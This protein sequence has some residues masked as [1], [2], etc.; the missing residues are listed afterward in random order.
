MSAAALGALT[1][2]AA[3][4]LAF[5]LTYILRTRDEHRLGGAAERQLRDRLEMARRILESSD[6]KPA[7]TWSKP[8][9][10]IQ[11]E[12]EI[13]D[14]LVARFRHP[15]SWQQINKVVV[16]L[17]VLQT[18]FEGSQAEEMGEERIRA[19]F[20]Q[21][22]D[23]VALL[24]S[25]ERRWLAS[26]PWLKRGDGRRGS[27][28]AWARLA[29]VALVVAGA[30]FGATSAAV[31][32]FDDPSDESAVEAEL[33]E[34]DPRASAINCIGD[35]ADDR[36][37]CLVVRRGCERAAADPIPCATNTAR[38]FDVQA[39]SSSGGVYAALLD[40]FGSAAGSAAKTESRP[41]RRA[42]R[43]WLGY[44]FRDDPPASQA[45]VGP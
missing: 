23:V 4:L 5:V 36:W 9:L 32:S 8:G 30:V 34:M 16:Q 37:T 10:R 17:D 13:W 11:L 44:L 42:L 31:S 18:W 6:C 29:A 40:T 19:S 14:R 33:R 1:T 2:I 24:D 26:R 43:T 45:V 38:E 21:T 20:Q 35:D 15:Y 3:A 22:K 41:P 39:D 25:R 27:L 7:K 12:P 28:R